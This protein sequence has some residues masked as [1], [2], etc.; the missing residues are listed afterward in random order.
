MI[1]T[2][3]ALTP[4]LFVIVILSSVFTAGALTASA[5]DRGRAAI[6]DRYK[7]NL[8]DLYPSDEAWRAAKEKLPAEISALGAFKGTLGSSAAHLADALDAINRV[9]KD[10]QRV[11]TYAG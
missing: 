4:V 11:A 10:V 8:A 5:Q 7:W 1:R 2:R 6:P 9:A 3:S